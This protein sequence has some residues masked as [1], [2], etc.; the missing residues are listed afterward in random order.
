MQTICN[1]LDVSSLICAFMPSYDLWAIELLNKGWHG[2]IRSEALRKRWYRY[3][4]CLFHMEAV[5][6][7]LKSQGDQKGDGSSLKDQVGHL[8][9]ELASYQAAVEAIEWPPSS[10]SGPASSSSSSRNSLPVANLL[11]GSVS[12]FGKD[13][14]RLNVCSVQ[15]NEQPL[16]QRFLDRAGL[17]CQ[18]EGIFRVEAFVMIHPGAMQPDHDFS[19]PSEAYRFPIVSKHAHGTG[20]ELRLGSTGPQ[21]MI[22]LGRGGTHYELSP[23]DLQERVQ[24]GQWVHIGARV[25]WQSGESVVYLRGRPIA[26]GNFRRMPWPQAPRKPTDRPLPH[27]RRVTGTTDELLFRPSSGPLVIAHNPNFNR[28]TACSV[29]DVWIYASDASD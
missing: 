10:A 15:A 17:L 4:H 1:Q 6:D 12:V 3:Q 19:I 21:F 24:P 16:P 14:Q 29:S 23:P 5:R 28:K 2:L 27:W 11:R 22:S 9:V 26:Q 13:V 8:D 18:S 25:D 7:D 20:W